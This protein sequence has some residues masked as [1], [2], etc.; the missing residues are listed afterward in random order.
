[1]AQYTVELRN[2]CEIYGREEVENWFKDYNLSDFL[3]S[4]QIAQIEK[5]NVWSKDRLAKKIVDHYFMREIGLETPALFKHYAKVYM[6]EIMERKLPKIYSN[7]FEYDPLSSVDYTEE[8]TREIKNENSSNGKS[9]STNSGTSNSTSNNNASGLNV[10]S[11][12]PEGTVGKDAILNGTYA[13]STNASETE[14][15]IQD[16]TI[17]SNDTETTIENSGNAKTLETYTHTMKGDNGVIVTN[18][19]LI[20]EY[21]EIIVAVDEEIIKELSKLF[22]RYILKRKENYIMS[23][24]IE[25]K[26]VNKV[27]DIICKF[28]YT[29]G[30]IP[31]SYKLG[32]TVEE[33]ILAIGRYLE[34]TVIPALNNNAEAVVELQNLY[35]ELKNY[36]DNYFDNLDVNTQIN[37]KLDEMA[38]NG[39]LSNL[40]APFVDEN[41]QEIENNVNNQNSK[42][43]SLETNVNT[44]NSRI[45]ELTSLPEGSTTGDAEL[46]DIRVS[47]FGRTFENAGDSVRSIMKSLFFNDITQDILET[48]IEGKYIG[49]PNYSIQTA[50]NF[51]YYTLHTVPG[52]LYLISSLSSQY[53]PLC[54]YFFNNTYN[55]IPK[56][57][58]QT[59]NYDVVIE[60]TGN[61][62]FIN[63]STVY[64]DF[65]VGELIN[66]DFKNL[67]F[68]TLSNI[69]NEEGKYV[70]FTG[71]TYEN[72]GFTLYSFTPEKGKFY[73]IKG[74][75]SSSA[76]LIYQNGGQKIPENL[77]ASTQYDGCYLYFPNQKTL[78]TV[79][80]NNLNARGVPEI[81]KSK[82][83]FTFPENNNQNINNIVGISKKLVCFG[84]SLTAGETYISDTSPKFYNNFY[85]F[86]YFLSKLLS[87]E[88]FENLGRGGAT[89]QSCW[90]NVVSSYNM[91]NNTLFTLWLGTNNAFT[92][93]IDTDC[94]PDTDYNTWADTQT[95]C[96]GK[97]IAKILSG[98]NNKIL[99]INNYAGTNKERNNSILQKFAQRFDCLY[100]DINNSN[101]LDENFHTAYNGYYNGIHLNGAGNNY[102]ANFIAN[103][104]SAKIKENPTFINFF[105]EV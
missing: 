64:E 54:A 33:Q 43:S 19:Y 13:S 78:N 27:Q 74:Y 12:T 15:K 29:I 59:Y 90:N 21:R 23:N 69:N 98:S 66:N 14:S 39:T 25:L 2:V 3:T 83:T 55:T 9:N 45:N 56:S 94:P 61:D 104:L 70:D 75:S 86:P 103:S 38:Q 6:N 82:F 92:D 105:E 97:I 18:Q 80:V 28:C 85:S 72:G 46:Q 4:E 89:A 16:E 53:A 44:L 96:M 101:V 10:A 102:V 95:G 31:T 30:M 20:R 17:T 79:Y 34:E 47:A 49:M 32:L 77:I 36:V 40:L 52:K 50:A 93:T 11:D 67:Y 48:K 81:Y 76:P 37:E 63:C 5:Y 88:S 41:F 99:L 35:I 68:D 22:M 51:N 91:P 24:L 58:G 71:R 1:M 60:G 57:V 65:F 7:F 84:D 87:C 100:I 73:L 26:P 62:V 42:I 8:Y